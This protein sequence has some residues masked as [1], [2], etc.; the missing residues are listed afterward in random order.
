MR[1]IL[2]KI[3][4][5]SG[6]CNYSFSQEIFTK[7]FSI[8]YK[9]KPYRTIEGKS[10]FVPLTSNSSLSSDDFLPYWSKSIQISNSSTL[11]SIEIKNQVWEKIQEKVS[12]EVINA[13]PEKFSLKSKEV[14]ARKTKQVLFAF[15]PLKLEGNEVYYLKDFDIEI[16]TSS[17]KVPIQKKSSSTTLNSVLRSGD[18]HKLAILN[19]GVYKISYSFLKQMGVDVSNLNSNWLNIYGNGVGLLSEDNSAAKPDD[20]IKNAIKVVDGGDGVFNDGDYILFYAYGPHRID[21]SASTLFHDYHIYSDTAFY[22]LSINPSDSPKRISTQGSISGANK[23]ITTFDELKYYQP[24]QENFIQSGR[25]WFGNKFGAVSTQ[26]VEFNFPNIN[27]ANRVTFRT[28]LVGRSFVNT[29]NYSITEINSGNSSTTGLISTIPNSSYSPYAR[30]VYH[31]FDFSPTNSNL[32]FSLTL[33]KGSDP[34]AEG[35]VD[36]I[37]VIANRNLTMTS[38]Q[39]SFSSLASVGT[40]S[41]SRFVISSAQDIDEIWEITNPSEVSS[42]SLTGTITKEFTLQTETLRK[43]VALVGSNFNSPI[44]SK[45]VENQNLHS[46]GYADLIIIANKEFLEEAKDL[47]SAHEEKGKTVH[48]VEQEQ[49]FNEFSSGIAD[50]TAI[51]MFMKMFYDRASTSAEV[52][53]HLLLFGDGSYDNRNKI[54][55]NTNYI[56]TYQSQESLSPTSTFTSDDYFVTLSDDESFLNTDMIDMGVGRFPVKSKAEARYA[57]DKAK[58][59][60]NKSSLNQDDRFASIATSSS[61]RDWRAQVALLA[62]DEDNSKFID[63]N[64]SAYVRILRT[65]PELNVTKI[66]MDAYKQEKTPGGQRYPQVETELKNRVQNGVLI[67]NFVGHGGEAGWTQERVLNTT[68]ISEWSNS[69]RPAIIMSATCQFSRWDNPSRTSGG[70]LAF[71][72]PR[73]AAVALFTT[74]RVVFATQNSLIINYFFDSVFLRING[75]PKDLGRIYMDTKNAFATF[76]NN[77]EHRKF[78]L[79]GDPSLQLGMPLHRTELT[80]LNDVDITNTSLDTLKALSKATIKGIVTDQKG[81][82]MPNFNGVTYVSIYDKKKIQQNLQNDEGSTLRQFEVQNNILFK[83]KV[84]VKNGEFSSTFIVPK[85]INYQ[86][87]KGRVSMYAEDGKEDA[88][89]YSDSLI[90]GGINENAPE[91]K[92]GPTIRLFMN[93]STFVNGGMTNENPILIAKL[94]DENGI[95][96]AGN[97]IGHDLGLILDDDFANPISVNEYYEAELDSYQKGEI[98]YAFSNLSVGRHTLTLKAYDVYNNPSSQ[99]IEFYVEQK[100]KITI[101]HVL[102]YPNPF[103]I[104]T[105]FMFQ[106]N[107][108][109]SYLRVRIEIFTITG[110]LVK[111][112]KLNAPTEGFNITPIEWNGRDE[113][114]DKLARGV[115]IYKVRVE[116]LAGESAEKFEKLVI[117]N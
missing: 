83:G 53:K 11:E 21:Y 58:I 107:Q 65:A 8:S 47:K 4:I 114:G 111:T 43:F 33:N 98:Q 105:Q 91:D 26:N 71:L 15:V 54:Q 81:A 27:S 50:A 19:D 17:N 63:D 113:F 3:L 6:F 59:Y 51:K 13:I 64:D 45:K 42:I 78:C 52:P 80:Q 72:N 73:G 28:V 23:T 117:L 44:F 101:D 103:T 10:L 9:V 106:H 100:D 110:K 41:I 67:L 37:E 7:H 61:L 35:W 14:D 77:P 104:R 75:V 32:N 20:L 99:T 30:E 57:V 31:T 34:D 36:Y 89:G 112:I 24:E 93:D 48:L 94:F 108:A 95:N 85:D 56:I 66:Y 109:A 86:Y 60:M 116:N 87:G 39:M 55:P 40:G 79:L 76:N 25:R 29:L 49:V 96:T 88:I 46:L 97:G 12:A 5:I 102:N 74:T 22:F 90:V 2:V 84:S 69:D 62:D 115:Y 92:I 18:W 82:F 68:T 1:N 70:E 16:K 38:S